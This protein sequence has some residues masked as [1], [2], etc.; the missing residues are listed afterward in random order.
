[1]SL[2]LPDRASLE[3]LKQLAKE[4]L[5]ALRVA[6]PEATLA[7]AQLAIA[8]D[9]GF[10]SWRALTAAIDRRRAPNVAAFIDAC[11]AGDVDALRAILAREPTLAREPVASGQTG[12]HLAVAHP[13]ALQVLLEHGADPDARDAG[14]NAYALHFAAAQGHIESVRVLLDAGGDVHGDGDEHRGG[15]IGW[16]ARRDNAPVLSL[17]IARGARHHIFS[18]MAIGDRTLVE[19]LVE[20]DPTCLLRRRSRFENGHT[21]LHAAFAPPDGLGFLAGGPDYDMLAL[22]IAAGADLE[23]TD[24]R[25]RTPLDVAILRGDE[26][27][28]ALLTAAGAVRHDPP[29]SDD[30][31][32]RLAALARSVRGSDP[33]FRVPDMRAT[34]QWYE[35]IGFSVLDEYED[36]DAL[37]FARLGYGRCTFA[38]TPG[39]DSGPRDVGLWIYSDRIQDLYA[40]L[41]NRQI[42]A[43][44][45]ASDERRDMPAVPF[46]EDLYTPFYGGRQFSIEDLNGLSIVFW[47]PDWLV[48]AADTAASQ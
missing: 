15:V 26:R 11:R 22:L 25:G 19:Q 6:D 14:D 29:S 42:R 32:E 36:G 40:L 21:P 44:T 3:F 41:K 38:L 28:I 34:V 7:G 1:M 33:M 12:L 45:G 35:S 31:R 47:Q 10:P 30:S 46:Q 39:S 13:A 5:A 16:A 4:R 23:S 20:D 9:Y 18:A 17:L 27:A 48:P 2:N 43:A 8:R 37:T 24:D